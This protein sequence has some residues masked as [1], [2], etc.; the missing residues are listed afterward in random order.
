MLHTVSFASVLELQFNNLVPHFGDDWW[1][2]VFRFFIARLDDEH[3]FEQFMLK[4]FDSPVTGS[5]SPKQ[6][7]LLLT[8][9]REA[10]QKQYGELIKK[11]FEPAT[12]ANRQRYLVECLRTIGKDD[13]IEAVRQFEARGASD[14]FVNT[15]ELDAH[16]IPIRG[17][18]FIYSVTGNK[19]TLP[20]F[21]IA[22]YPVTNRQYRRFIEYLESGRLDDREVMLLAD[23]RKVLTAFEGKMGWNGWLKRL[24]A[25]PI[26]PKFFDHERMTTNAS[27]VMSSRLFLLTGMP[28][29]PIACGCR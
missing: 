5:L 11:L 18:T 8:L 16:Y 13:A 28:P 14:L 12:S 6:Q 1:S 21:R 29:A 9:V 25:I 17:G 23:F 7:E 26:L 4:L 22:R 20:D 10:P 2:E 19:V 15:Q 3:L 24:R 27:M